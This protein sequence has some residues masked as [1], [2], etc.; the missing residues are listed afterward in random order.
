MDVE[1]YKLE[2]HDVSSFQKLVGVYAHVF[3]MGSFT[4]PGVEY[5]QRLLL[6]NSFFAFV[7][8]VSGEII[9]GT[10]CYVL[11]QYYTTSSY[12]YVFDLAV[13]PRYQRLGFGRRLMQAVIAH[14]HALGAEEV[15]VQADDA[16]LHAI[17]FY[18]SS[19]GTPEKVTHFN[20]PLR[21][22]IK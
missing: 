21:A 15:F 11:E 2:P 14:S 6:K 3:D 16:D 5:L 7:A 12:V 20:Y 8:A 9:G 1:V 18:R 13:H 17:E 19:G 10:T 4:P 22:P